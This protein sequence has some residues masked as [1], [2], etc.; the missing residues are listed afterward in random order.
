M[1]ALKPQSIQNQ[2]IS[3][4]FQFDFKDKQNT[5]VSLLF[6]FTIKGIPQPE[7]NLTF[8]S[9]SVSDVIQG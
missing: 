4:V 7:I 3:G 6:S 8:I 1:R 5:L 2:I 9:P